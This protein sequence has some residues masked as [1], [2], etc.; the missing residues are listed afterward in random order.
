[1]ASI[2]DHKEEQ[3]KVANNFKD[4][5]KFL[6][7]TLSDIIYN[8]QQ[9][10]HRTIDPTLFA[11][12]SNFVISVNPHDMLVSFLHGSF[13]KWDI[14]KNKDKKFLEERLPTLFPRVRQLLGEDEFKS[15]SSLFTNEEWLTQDDFD[16]LWDFLESQVIQCIKY[17]HWSRQP[18]SIKE[19]DGR[20][21]VYL[22]P[23]VFSHV[24]VEEDADATTKRLVVDILQLAETWDVE[25]DF[26]YLIPSTNIPST[27]DTPGGD[28]VDTLTYTLGNTVL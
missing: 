16:Y 10:G 8:L 6:T 25:L 28:E 26:G 20:R 7:E 11:L 24:E 22:Q 14:I 3:R 27:P 21:D 15:F 17:V 12:G 2:V 23:G 5:V 4:N 18:C 1:M 19:K 13:D 9:R